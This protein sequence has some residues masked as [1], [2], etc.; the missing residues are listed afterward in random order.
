MID[1]FI[2]Q[3]G[4]VELSP[5][6]FN[7]YSLRGESASAN[8]IRR[9]NLKL[10]LETML[11]LQPKMILVGEAPSHRGARLTG[12]AFVS[13]TVLLHGVP[14]APEL[15]IF[16]AARGYAKSKETER[17]STEA[18]ASM[19]WET[20]GRMSPPPLLWNAFPFH[21]FKE[22][23]RFSNRMPTRGE[24]EIGRPLLRSLI[25]L[26]DVETIV[27]VGNHAAHSLTILGIEHELVR[28]PSMGGKKQFV[29]GM[30]KLSGWRDEERSLKSERS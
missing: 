29:A 18:S 15:P 27:A 22:G 24:L 20:V 26:F 4:R 10:Y 14:T 28:H 8:R 19:V 21:P 16:G 25:E 1:R 13:E 30:E 12:L 9:S 3:L 7:Q 6:A 2:S 23:N 5:L 11:A 17:L